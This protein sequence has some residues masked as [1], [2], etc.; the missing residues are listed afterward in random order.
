MS[1]LVCEQSKF[2]LYYGLQRKREI[3]YS[4]NELFF[5]RTLN[6]LTPMRKYHGGASRR[7]IG[8]FVPVFIQLTYILPI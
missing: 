3:S 4:Q 2:N 7:P 5:L 8:T 6:N 1:N